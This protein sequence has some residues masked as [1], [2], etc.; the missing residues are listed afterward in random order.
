MVCKRF[1]INIIQYNSHTTSGIC[2][3]LLLCIM[4]REEQ[5]L[6]DYV[7]LVTG[8][9]P[10]LDGPPPS[11]STV[12]LFLREHYDFGE[13]E[14]FGRRVSLAL[15]KTQPG[16]FSTS[17]YAR[18]AAILKDRFG[19]DIVLVIPKLPSY[20]RNR[21]VREGVP[22]IVPGAQMF[23]PMLMVDL[24]ERFSKAKSR[25]QEKLSPVSQLMVIYQILRE[26]ETNIPLAILGTRLEY[27]PQAISHAQE[28]LQA[29]K[30]CEVRR[31]GRMVFLDFGLRGKTL[32]KR[33]EPRMTSPVRRTQWVRW[34]DPRARAVASGTT[35]LS[36]LSML[37]EDRVATYAMRD[38]ALRTE[39]EKGGLFSCGGPEEAD[40]R[41]ESWKYDP[42]VLAENGVADPCSLYL[43]LRESGDER[44]Q[45]EI[46]P[47]I[48]RL[49]K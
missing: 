46:Q 35:A 9:R 1:I 23:L 13:I 18:N 40:A 32:W 25:L 38:R 12:P 20:V 21:L 17:E 26:P 49:P 44:V 31:A 7:E 42:W 6:L 37:A 48:E 24:R 5:A 43:S 27:S 39:L 28:E 14:M 41:M 22:F 8:V 15:E 10:R 2:S 34:G 11:T 29:A 19:K 16:E 33:A 47:L 36:R 30:L 4:I 45:K 3:V